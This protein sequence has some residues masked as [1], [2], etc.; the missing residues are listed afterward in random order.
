M[1]HRQST[2]CAHCRKTFDAHSGINHHRA[3]KAGDVTICIGCAGINVFIKRLG[4][5]L[6]LRKPTDSELATL[7][8]DPDVTAAVLAVRGLFDKRAAT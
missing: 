5:R 1:T 3:P 4:H 6:A 8:S 2:T 7:T